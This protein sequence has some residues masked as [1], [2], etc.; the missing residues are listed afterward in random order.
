MEFQHRQATICK[1]SVIFE[2]QKQRFG[3]ISI[4]L[5]KVHTSEE[6]SLPLNNP[7]DLICLSLV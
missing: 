4:C 3:K 2:I 6:V 1:M 5:W 7:N